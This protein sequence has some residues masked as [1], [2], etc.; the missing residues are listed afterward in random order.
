VFA[1]ELAFYGTLLLVCL[2]L[3]RRLHRKIGLG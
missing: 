1:T 3:R 2:M